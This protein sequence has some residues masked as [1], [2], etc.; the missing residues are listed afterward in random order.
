MGDGLDISHG[1]A[2]AVDT[3][4]LRMVAVRLRRLVREVEEARDDLRAARGAADEA[5]LDLDG[6]TMAVH[7]LDGIRETLSAAARGTELM[8]EAYEI[9]ELRA[10]AAL[11]SASDRDEAAALMRDADLLAARSPAAAAAAGSLMAQWRRDRFAGFT[12]QTGWAD[13]V[14]PGGG[15]VPGGPGSAPMSVFT[16]MWLGGVVA[17]ARGVVPVSTVLAPRPHALRLTPTAV[18][19]PTG[20]PSGLA[21]AIARFPTTPGAQV[22]VEGYTAPDGARRFVAYIAG[23]RP[24]LDRTEPWDMTA[25]LQLYAERAEAD[26]LQAVRDALADAGAG[27]GARVDLVGHS[28]G[29]MIAALLAQGEEYDVRAVVTFGSP[30]EAELPDDVLGVTVRHTDDPVSSLAGGGLPQGTGA[31][32]S[33]VIERIGDPAQGLHDLTLRTHLLTTYAET[34]ALA[35]SSDD[36]RIAALRE[37]LAEGGDLAD[38]VATDYRARRP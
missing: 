30:I 31:R 3:A 25:N 21:D 2:L 34:A 15:L 1:G 20:P 33:M 11:L 27:P 6:V 24:T 29:G 8:A 22:R 28:Q 16:G 23:T 7:R 36:P 13:R 14:L 32:G 35:D 17:S 4:E 37:R 12:T 19:P 26:S 38:V 5:R 9:V 18:A 10:R